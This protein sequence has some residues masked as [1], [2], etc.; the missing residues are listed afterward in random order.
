MRWEGRFD[1]M[2][3]PQGQLLTA[4]ERHL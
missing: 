1:Q 4:A 2:E 3:H